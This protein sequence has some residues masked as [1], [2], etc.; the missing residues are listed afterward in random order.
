ML[1]AQKTDASVKPRPAG[2]QLATSQPAAARTSKVQAW[3]GDDIP[4]QCQ[5][6]DLLDAYR[7]WMKIAEQRLPRL[8]DIV[9]PNRSALPDNAALLLR[10]PNDFLFVSQ[11]SA[12]VRILGRSYVGT[13]HSEAQSALVSDIEA[14]YVSAID[15]KRPHYLR[16]VSR[17]SERHFSLEQLV[18][19]IAADDS[20]EATFVLF[21]IAALDDKADILRAIFDRS[22]IG[23]IAALPSGGDGAKPDD[24]R[25]LMIN[26]HAK[27]ILKLPES[28]DRIS[29]VRDL[30]PWF[31]DGALWTRTNTVSEGRQT[32]IH[33]RD[34]NTGTSYRLTIEPIS[35]FMLFSI[36]EVLA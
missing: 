10:I 16:F 18:L 7:H 6:S 19:P 35:R 29:T 27:R 28:M 36:I 5:A 25:I 1:T 13:L 33:Y 11:G 21:F 2:P 14:N 22:P 20:G 30:G 31:R 12:A 34:R 3:A 15:H 32:H 17:S 4:S 8:S 24:G 23:M 26:A 9:G